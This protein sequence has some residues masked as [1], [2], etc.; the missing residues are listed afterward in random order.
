M[1]EKNIRRSC[2]DMDPQDRLVS[3]I[4]D[5]LMCEKMGDDWQ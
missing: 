4:I 2:D 1:E 3:T 5:K